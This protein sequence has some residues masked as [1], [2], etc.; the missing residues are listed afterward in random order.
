VVEH[1]GGKIDAED[2][3]MSWVSVKGQAG[4]DAHFQHS[5]TRWDPQSL[6][7][8]VDSPRKNASEYMVIE[9]RKIG[10]D[11]TSVRQFVLLHAILL[12]FAAIPYPNGLRAP[13]V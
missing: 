4:A 6:H 11:P 13:G 9:A 8:R 12:S 3:A 5:R 2:A 7:D 1:L 10:I